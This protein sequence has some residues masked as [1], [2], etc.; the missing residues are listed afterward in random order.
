MKTNK[1]SSTLRVFSMHYTKQQK[2]FVFLRTT[3]L[4]DLERSSIIYDTRGV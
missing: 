1:N 2:N 4:L 3:F